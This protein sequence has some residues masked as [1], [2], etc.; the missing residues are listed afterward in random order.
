MDFSYCNF[1]LDMKTLKF[2]PANTFLL[3]GIETLLLLIYY[4]QHIN[5]KS[6]MVWYW[7]YFI[8]L[9]YHGMMTL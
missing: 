1:D 7:I 2:P 3:Q 6:N 9:S 4:L 5:F 8:T